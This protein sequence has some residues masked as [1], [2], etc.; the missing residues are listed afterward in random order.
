MHRPHSAVLA[1]ALVCA[2]LPIHG[3]AVE[4][5]AGE[6]YRFIASD[7]STE[8]HQLRGLFVTGLPDGGVLQLGTR[9]IRPGDAVPVDQI[10]RLL[11][12]ASAAQENALTQVRCIP[13]FAGRTAPETAV[14]ISI[15]GRRDH[16]PVAEDSQ[17]ETYKNLPNSSTLK[18]SDPEGQPLRFV[19]TQPPKR[20]NVELESDGSFVYTPLHNKVGTD[21]FCYVAVDPAGNQSRQ[22][23]VT[24]RI[25][26]PAEPRCYADTAGL[27]C[28]FAAEWLRNTQVFSGEQ[29][30]GAAY[31]SPEK[32]VSRGQFLT[33]LMQVLDMPAD[34]SARVTGFI[35]SAP[36]WL[37][38]YLAAA[39]RSGLVRGYPSAR[40]VVF[41]PGQAITVQEAAAMSLRAAELA[42]PAS[43]PAGTL[44]DPADTPP[45]QLLTRADAALLLYRLDQLRQSRQG[46]S[47][48]AD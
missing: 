5:N 2:L 6:S 23:A 32:P 14:P 22:A 21:V 12:H 33:M 15:R 41:C 31:F 30:N 19:L 24:V 20:G 34:R 46:L 44:P 37:K 8:P 11:F 17:L 9:T 25:R 35:D 43:A 36:D 38:P 13:I 10:D 39:F 26:K 3:Q 28:R 48:L 45:S 1:C 18:A 7:F 47:F 27:D 4:M 40:G 29:I 16:P 42:I